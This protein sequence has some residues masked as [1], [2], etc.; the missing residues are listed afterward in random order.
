MT[1]PNVQRSKTALERL[2]SWLQ[3]RIQK[4]HPA[5]SRSWARLLKSE[6]DIPEIYRPFFDSLPPQARQPFP[7]TV[8]TPT[9]KGVARR[10][11]R[12][13]LVCLTDDSL[14][15]VESSDEPP[16]PVRYPLNGRCLVERG[17]ILLHSW[18]TIHDPTGD[19][20]SAA[21]TVRFNSVTDHLMVT[22]VDRLRPAPTDGASASVEA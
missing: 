9:F 5:D 3:P 14:F 15:I 22:F 11:E 18:I 2:I 6:R 19:G 8:L 1:M 20:R 13:K 21:T 4:V 10:V 16:A 17:V 12:E 7:H